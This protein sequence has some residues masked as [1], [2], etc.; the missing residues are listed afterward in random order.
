MTMLK[1]GVAIDAWKLKIFKRH[2]DE[3]GYQYTEHPGATKGSLLLNVATE[4]V[5]AL[6]PVIEKAQ[7]E[8]TKAKMH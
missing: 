5:A 6:K 2:L 3:A 7:K 8:C 1:A 4:T